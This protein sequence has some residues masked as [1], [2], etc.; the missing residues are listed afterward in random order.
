MKAFLFLIAAMAAAQTPT[1]GLSGV[2]VDSVTHQ[3][4][5]RASVSLHVMPGAGSGGFN[6]PQNSQG[7]MTAITDASGS[8]SF[9]G[10]VAGEVQLHA[11]H[12]NYMQQSGASVEIKPGEMATAT[13]QLIPGAVLSGH[14]FDEDGDPLSGCQVNPHPASAIDR[15]VPARGNPSS[16]IDGAFRLAG[17]P[18]GKYIVSVE[19]QR[20]VFEPRPFSSGPDPPPTR[21]YPVEFYP[22]VTDAKSAEVIDLAPGVEKAGVDFRVTPAPVTQVRGTFSGDTWRGQG[23]LTLQLVNVN[24]EGPGRTVNGSQFDLA[25]GTFEFPKVFPGSYLLVGFSNGRPEDR[26]GTMAHVEVKD[27]PVELSLDWHRAVDVSGTVEVENHNNQPVS[28]QNVS[29]LLTPVYWIGMPLAQAQVQQDGSFTIHS[30]LPG[31]WRIRAQGPQVF[32]K[33]AWA[34]SDDLTNRALDLSAGVA[35]DLHIVLSNNTATVRGTGTPGKLIRAQPEEE[36]P[37][38]G[39]SSTQIDSNGQFTL[40]GLAPGKYRLIL[41]DPFAQITEA[42]GGKEVRVGEGETVTVDLKN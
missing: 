14:V 23:N 20:P 22:A 6:N 37:F 9:N 21:A 8:F 12:P 28:I 13:V 10:I 2:V 25:K 32:V 41:S 30:A 1:G 3:P 39:V 35:G 29:I 36:S 5:K 17:I 16:D 40:T 15:G 42:D 19:C 7:P 26:I 27:Q 24:G 4:V 34:G 33:S 18:A 11:T 31:M 38:M